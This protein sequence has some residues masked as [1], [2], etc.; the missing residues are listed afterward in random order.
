[1]TSEENK[2]TL[3]LIDKALKLFPK[4]LKEK[5][6]AFKEKKKRMKAFAPLSK[7]LYRDE[8]KRR[9]NKNTK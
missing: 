3:K 6:E 1:M 9:A 5:E 4:I 8:L 2:K 7:E